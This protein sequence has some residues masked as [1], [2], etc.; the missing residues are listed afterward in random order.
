MKRCCA[1][2][3]RAA[4]S[5][6]PFAGIPYRLV[7]SIPSDALDGRTPAGT[8]A[9]S[10]YGTH[11][12]RC[13]RGGRINRYI[14]LGVIAKFFPPKIRE[15]LEQTKRAVPRARSSSTRMVY[16]VIALT[17]YM[18]SLSGGIAVLLEG[19]SGSWSH[20]PA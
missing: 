16:Y 1:R 12:L 10:I 5:I 7:P 6:A 9:R 20:L 18:R 19:Y 13:R 8:A 2:R 4:I 3:Q 17:L 11:L 14:S 15:I